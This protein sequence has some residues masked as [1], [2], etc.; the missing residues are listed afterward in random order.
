MQCF[1][2]PVVLS[3]FYSSSLQ[4][5]SESARGPE[6]A[7]RCNGNIFLSPIDLSCPETIITS[8]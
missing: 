6:Q 5:V 4:G 8:V 2:E 7:S 3:G 1:T